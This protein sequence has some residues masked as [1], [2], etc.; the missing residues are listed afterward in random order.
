[1]S[2]PGLWDDALGRLQSVGLHWATL[3]LIGTFIFFHRKAEYTQR[4]PGCM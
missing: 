2:A 4:R 1:M 3:S